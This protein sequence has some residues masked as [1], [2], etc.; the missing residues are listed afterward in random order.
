[1]L[2]SLEAFKEGSGEIE[3]PGIRKKGL[4]GRKDRVTLKN[5][6]R[7]YKSRSPRISHTQTPESV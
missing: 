3:A 7:E 6:N 2:G 1:M 4:S 5:S